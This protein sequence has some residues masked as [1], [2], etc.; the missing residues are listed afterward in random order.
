VKVVTSS[1]GCL[2]GTASGTIKFTPVSSYASGYTISSASSGVQE[3]L[4]AGCGISSTTFNNSQ[5]NVTIPA[6]GPNSSL[7]TYNI[8]GTIYLHSNQSVLSGYGASAELSGAWG[9]FAGG[10]S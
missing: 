1:G 5:C 6:N 7:N 3:T 8:Y 9:L 4:N 2:S 10:R